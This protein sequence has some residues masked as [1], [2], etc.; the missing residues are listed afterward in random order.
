MSILDTFYILFKTDA[1]EAAE[2]I[3]DVDRAADDVA[4]SLK[5]ADAAGKGTA[6]SLAA[7]AAPAAIAA[8]AMAAVGAAIKLAIERVDAIDEIGDTAG[9]LRSTA[10]DYDAFV[11]AVRS[12][13]GTIADASANLANFGDKL[14]DAAARP[15]GINARNFAKWGIHF[16]DTKG[17]ALG[18]VDGVLALAKSLE[19]LDQAQAI[20]R[21]RKLGIED[22]DTIAFLLEGKQAILD[23]MDAEKRAGVVTDRQIEIAGEYQAAMG[24]LSNVIDSY[25]NDFMEVLTPAITGA[26]RAITE[27]FKWTREHKNLVEGFFIGVSG[28]VTAVYLPAMARAAAATLAATWPFLLVAGAIIA[29]GAAF[30]LAYEDV[31]A[32]MDG[33]PSLI[34]ELA[35][36]Y[37]SFG[38]IV[39]GIGEWFKNNPSASWFAAMLVA[40]RAAAAVARRFMSLMGMS[41]LGAVGG[42]GTKWGAAFGAA[43]RVAV[44]AAFAGVMLEI[45]KQFDPKG[46]LG[47]LTKPVDDWLR[48]KMGLQ[49]KEGGVTPDEIIEWWN[50]EPAP[51]NDNATPKPEPTPE[52]LSPVAADLG[53]GDSQAIP[54]AND[55]ASP[56]PAP[57]QYRPSPR[58]PLAQAAAVPTALPQAQAQAVAQGQ[59]LMTAAAGAP[60][61]AQTAATV[62]APVQENKTVNNTVE[63]GSVVIHTQAVDAKGIAAA[64]KSGLKTELREASAQFDDGVAR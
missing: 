11:R 58:G 34:G 15:D 53:F 7:M 54:P 14:N 50:K 51:A 25:S 47:G 42:A 20:G 23:K 41:S 44:V 9:K 28:V 19:G 60:I 30:A 57:K 24:Q 10:Q 32:F 22:A 62:A 6:H 13:G 18:A 64:I 3:K 38:K 43:A 40:A 52:K 8:A 1:K 16:K 61:S 29:V 36:K 46:N 17:N 12:T 45:L 37:E 2:E 35:K 49:P 39:K 31:K 21:L 63:V 33:Q 27:A 48:D 55:N 4:D 5:A 26:V 56:E 59:R